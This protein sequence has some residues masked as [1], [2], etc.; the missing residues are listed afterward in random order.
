[1]AERRPLART[2]WLLAAAPALLG[3][4]LWTGAKAK[5]PTRCDR[6]ASMV[7]LEMAGTTEGARSLQ[8]EW[9]EMSGL[10]PAQF[11]RA[12]RSALRWDFAFIA[13]YTAVLV[14][15]CIAI[16][17]TAKGQGWV[18]VVAPWAAVLALAAGVLDVVENAALRR[19]VSG[20]VRETWPL[21]ARA[22]AIPKFALAALVA[23]FV[24]V[25]TTVL[26]ARRV[27]RGP[28]TWP[29]PLLLAAPLGTWI[30]SYPVLVGVAVLGLGVVWRV[31]LGGLG[32]PDLF[33]HEAKRYQALA[34]LGTGLLA[35]D[36]GLIGFLL[37]APSPW[38]TRLATGRGFPRIRDVP[39][40]GLVSYLLLTSAPIAAAA[41][42]SLVRAEVESRVLFPVG[43]ITGALAYGFAAVYVWCRTTWPAWVM[44]RVPAAVRQRARSARRSGLGDHNLDGLAV[45]LMTLRLTLVTVM[46][47]AAAVGGTD[48]TVPP[49]FAICLILGTVVS[50]YGLFVFYFRL[51][52]F[53]LVS[54]LVLAI[55]LVNGVGGAA[56]RIRELDYALVKPRP[57]DARPVARAASGLADDRAALLAWIATYAPRGPLVVVSVDG[58]GVRAA[59]WTMAV[60]T[61]LEQDLGPGFASQVRVVT[62]A[63]GGMQGAAYFVG[64]LQMT[65]SAPTPQHL[66]A[67]GNLI[68]I[69]ALREGVSRDSLT[70]LGKR[71]VLHDLF[72]GLARLGPDRGDAIQEAWTLHTRGV[73]G[74]TVRSLQAGE[75]AGWRPSLVLSPMIVEDGR[76]LLV[77]NLD[78]DAVATQ[79]T[80]L[81]GTLGRGALE[82]ARLFPDA[83]ALKLGTAV[84][85]NATFPYVMPAVE[86]PTAPPLRVVDAGYYDEHGVSVAAAWLLRH[87][88]LL[89]ERVGRVILIQVPDALAAL[90]KSAPCNDRRSLLAIGFSGLT[91]PVEGTFSGRAALAAYS[92]DELIEVLS[93]ALN[94]PDAPDRF[95]TVSF[96]PPYEQTSCGLCARSEEEVPLSWSINK[97]DRDRLLGGMNH[98]CNLDKRRE[99]Q[100]WWT[101]AVSPALAGS[102]R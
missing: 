82:F 18:S 79:A 55:A 95:V 1:M 14:A 83:A 98:P 48:S 77:S 27:R 57:G 15:A 37:D 30:L 81:Q 40:R 52:R 70:P 8:R 32:I 72:P 62:G 53:G 59:T 24:L 66:D 101:P 10:T 2:L 38:M 74:A 88:T 86:L 64:S 20:S 4:L 19:I 41:V 13:V 31:L 7:A 45:V 60:L 99:L 9:Q 22:C 85:M 39:A 3:L 5:G 11:P 84:R 44:D 63:S 43:V 36:L 96:E 12:M 78:L 49:G 93:G 90:K 42:A 17:R 71:L 80:E 67:G 87:S 54:V 21:L 102:G 68:P 28:D 6:V 89:R 100:R 34:G 73:F 33:W 58:G 50:V 35:V 29:V 75:V 47:V 65:D 91:T 16:R 56:H 25:A 92:N 46:V 94:T 51:H 76:R 97:N 61:Q 69:E 23:L 26:V